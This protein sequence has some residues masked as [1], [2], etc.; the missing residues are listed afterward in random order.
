[1]NIISF[2]GKCLNSLRFGCWYIKRSN[3]WFSC[4]WPKNIR[5]KLTEWS[6][7]ISEVFC[8]KIELFIR[9][10][11]RSWTL[12]LFDC[13]TKLG[14]SGKEQCVAKR[15]FLAAYSDTKFGYSTTRWWMEN[16]CQRRRRKSEI[17][18][19][20]SDSSS[21]VEIFPRWFWNIVKHDGLLFISN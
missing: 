16:W 14:I 17:V 1:M 11:I 21:I 20:G 13:Q 18:E 10:K 19:F 8:T 3:K 6:S 12:H 15:F 9:Y 2:P 4:L 5:T 7:N